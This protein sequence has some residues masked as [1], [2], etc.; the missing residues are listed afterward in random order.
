[1][2]S[3]QGLGVRVQGLGF[4]VEGSGFGC[5]RMKSVK[6]VFFEDGFFQG[7]GGF[8]M[9]SHKGLILLGGILVRV[10]VF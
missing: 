7:C 1:M 10:W 4:R 8:R 9:I 2:N 5:L 6:G 3:S